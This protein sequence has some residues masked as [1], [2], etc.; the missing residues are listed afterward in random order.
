MP[1]E[2]KR[3]LYKCGKNYVLPIH[4]EEWATYGQNVLEDYGNLVI[5]QTGTENLI[6]DPIPHTH[7]F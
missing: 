4:I 6:H 1:L 2:E 3:K 5:T 7:A